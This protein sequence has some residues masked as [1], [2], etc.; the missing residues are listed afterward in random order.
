VF[1]AETI[2]AAVINV[3]SFAIGKLYCSDKPFF[4]PKIH[5]IKPFICEGK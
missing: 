5:F 4:K 3:G 1:L 2:V